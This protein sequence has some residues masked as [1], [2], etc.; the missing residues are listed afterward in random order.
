MKT[1]TNEF[2]ET[3]NAANDGDENALAIVRQQISG[4][5]GQYIV[6]NCGN[7][8]RQAE[9]SLIR[10]MVG[11]QKA[12]CLAI[13]EKVYQ[14]RVSLGGPS[15][16]PLESILVDRV[17]VTWLQVQHADLIAIQTVDCSISKGNYL[18]KRQ[19]NAHRMHMSAIKTLATVR[20]MQLPTLVAIQADVSLAGFVG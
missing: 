6:D 11:D 3:V 17:I 9:E 4:P 5:R 7:L 10:A 19:G 13:K 15:P 12:F 8:A 14:M 1:Q 16:S 20:K 18:Q 2:I